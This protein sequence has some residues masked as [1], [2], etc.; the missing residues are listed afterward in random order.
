M[1]TMKKIIAI[2]I[3]L[4]I[5]IA[6]G[7]DD[8]ATRSAEKIEITDNGTITDF[9]HNIIAKDFPMPAT[10]GFT[11]SFQITSEDAIGNNFT[12]NFLP[13]VATC[14]YDITTPTYES[15][16]NPISNRLSIDGLPIDNTNT[17]NQI[18]INYTV[19]GTTIGDNIKIDFNGKY[20]ETDGTLH[21]LLG[22]IDINRDN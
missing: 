19:F 16:F 20:Y 18:D 1:E 12:L 8:T 7:D 11:C 6:C 13:K 2:A 21:N 14:P 4:T 5:T 3:F 15:I 17:N 22:T 9:S 10:T